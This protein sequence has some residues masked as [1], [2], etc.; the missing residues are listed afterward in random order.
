VDIALAAGQVDEFLRAA[1]VSG[2]DVL[3][4]PA[5]RWP[6]LMHKETGIQVD[7]LPEERPF[8]MCRDGICRIEP[9]R[10]RRLWS[11]CGCPFERK[12][13]RSPQVTDGPSAHS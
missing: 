7:I 5:G 9:S 3:Q 2:F 6:K 1:A 12:I 8:L 10:L 4:P 13:Q 11:S